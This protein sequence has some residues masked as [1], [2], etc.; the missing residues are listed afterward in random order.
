MSGSLLGFIFGHFVWG[1]FGAVILSFIGNSILYTL[2]GLFIGDSVILDIGEAVFIAPFVQ[3]V[4]MHC[5]ATASFGAMLGAAKNSGGLLK[6]IYPLIGISTAM[7]M[8]FMWNLTVSFEST[9][10]LGFVFMF[11]VVLFFL[12]SFMFLSRMKKG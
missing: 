12:F 6:I 10:F 9:F 8:H 1:A 11:F 2:L 7:F 5:I 3:E 4:M